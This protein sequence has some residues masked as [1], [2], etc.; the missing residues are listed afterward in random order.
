MNFSLKAFREDFIMG[1]LPE[2]I[3]ATLTVI[4]ERAISFRD[5]GL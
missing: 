5:V 1:V 4:F 2:N 3:Q